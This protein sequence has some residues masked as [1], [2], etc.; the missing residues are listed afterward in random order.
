MKARIA[1]E[2]MACNHDSTVQRGRVERPVEA[3]HL[4]NVTRSTDGTIT[5]LTYIPI[6]K[7]EGKQ[8]MHRQGES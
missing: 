4:P 8:Y 6:S 2:L 5:L 7:E 3:T 1:I